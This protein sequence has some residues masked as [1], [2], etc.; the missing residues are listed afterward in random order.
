MYIFTDT[1]TKRVSEYD[2]HE[3]AWN[4]YENSETKVK[5]VFLVV[6]KRI[7]AINTTADFFNRDIEDLKDLI[8]GRM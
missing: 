7:R 3:E 4:A 1:E 6:G 5:G 8:K 2:T